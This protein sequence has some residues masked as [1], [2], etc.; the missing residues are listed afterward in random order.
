MRTLTEV[1][2]QVVI[3]VGVV[4]DIHVYLNSR[5]T[6]GLGVL[7]FWLCLGRLRETCATGLERDTRLG[8]AMARGRQ[9][10]YPPLL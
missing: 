9:V 2:K 3:K 4:K 1:T 8:C 7:L 5:P 10:R 6:S